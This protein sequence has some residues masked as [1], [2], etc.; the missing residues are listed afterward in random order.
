MG[1]SYLFE[2]SKC[3]YQAS[4]SGGS[5]AGFEFSVQTAVCRDC[6]ILFDAV[7]R[8]RMPDNGIMFEFQRT[9]LKKV[10]PEPPTF[11]AALNRL[12]PPALQKFKWVPFKIRCV[13]SAAH[14]VR[15]WNEP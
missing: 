12:P 7:V 2:C 13:V 3:G 8:C 5:D 14:R 4:V 1:R 15:A 11:E 10:E 9:R 6:R